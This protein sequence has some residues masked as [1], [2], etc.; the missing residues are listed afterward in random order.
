MPVNRHCYYHFDCAL[1]LVMELIYFLE[2]VLSETS[3]IVICTRILRACRNSWVWLQNPKRGKCK[4]HAITISIMELLSLTLLH[5]TPSA[6]C[7]ICCSFV[8]FCEGCDRNI[9]DIVRKA[10]DLKSEYLGVHLHCDFSK[11][12]GQVYW[13]LSDF[14]SSTVTWKRWRRGGCIFMFQVVVK[15]EILWMWLSNNFCFPS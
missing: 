4:H 12:R 8:L 14:V 3:C 6:K 9:C 11:W 7:H 10:L 5:I 13:L 15:M 1:G 2:H